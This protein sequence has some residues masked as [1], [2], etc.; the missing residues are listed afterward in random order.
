MADSIPAATADT[1]VSLTLWTAPAPVAKELALSD[2][3]CVVAPRSRSAETEDI[4]L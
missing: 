2:E 3:G 4:V 1:M